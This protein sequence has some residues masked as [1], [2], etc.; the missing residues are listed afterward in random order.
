MFQLVCITR[1]QV[2]YLTNNDGIILTKRLSVI[3]L[4]MLVY[5]QTADLEHLQD[6]ESSV[7][8]LIQE[9]LWFLNMDKVCLLFILCS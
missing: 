2:F 5:P 7:K 3:S 1:A 4:Q 6:M 8:S 9:T